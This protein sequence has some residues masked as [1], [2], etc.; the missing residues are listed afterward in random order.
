LW[1]EGGRSAEIVGQVVKDVQFLSI[2]VEMCDNELAK[3]Y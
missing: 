3:I 1:V 2:S